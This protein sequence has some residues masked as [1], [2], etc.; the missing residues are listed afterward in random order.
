R[1]LVAAKVRVRG[2]AATVFNWARRQMTG[3][4]IMVP[5]G[6]DFIV[7]EPELSSPFDQPIIALDNIAKFHTDASL[8]ERLHVRGIVTLQRPGLDLYLQ[9]ETGGLHLESRQALSL[10]LGRTIEAVGF[11]EI[12]NYQPM[13]RDVV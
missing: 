8:G 13:L 6:E 4:S 9:D 1:S 2:T 10:P 7:E 11:L 5:N 12:V 3:V